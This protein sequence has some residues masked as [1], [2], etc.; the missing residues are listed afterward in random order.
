MHARIYA[1]NTAGAFVGALAAGFWL[2][3]Q[4]GLVAVLAATSV[5]NLVAGALYVGLGR[6]ARGRATSEA[7][8][9]ATPEETPKSVTH[10]APARAGSLAGVALLVGFAMMALQTTLVRLGG[11]ALGPS[12]Y[13]F[14]M[15]V[16]VFVLCIA[17][18]SFAVGALARV[19][20][21]ALPCA[22]WTLAVLLGALYLHADDAPYW[23]HVLRSGFPREPEAF[24]SFQL[25]AFGSL[26]CVSGPP[27]ILSGA[28]LP[29]VFDALKRERVDLGS[30]AG[31]IYA[32]NT[33]GSL[34]GALVGGYTL[35]FWLDLHAVVRVAIA[36]V[37]LAAALATLR[38]RPAWRLASVAATAAVAA[39]GVALP[40]LPPWDPAR[41]SAGLFREPLL[42]PPFDSASDFW[43]RWE[44]WP[45]VF[46]TDDPTASVAVKRSP[47]S[48]ALDGEL[49]LFT[50]GKADGSV[51][52]DYLT[53]AMAGLLPA[54]LA[55]QAERAFVIGYGTGITAGVLA[56]LDSIEQVVVAEISPG[57]IEAAPL[58][59]WANGDASHH[60]KIELER[61]DALR[62][63]ARSPGEF[64][65]VVSEPSNPWMAG[66]ELL[67]SRE[68]LETSR[69]RLRPGGVH[70]QWLPAYDSDSRTLAMVLHTY[71]EVFEHVAVWCAVGSDLL[72]L[73]LRDA[74]SALDVAR[75]EA[76]ARRADFA[77]ALTRAGI[78]S[79]PALLAHELLPLGVANALE[80]PG[81]TH[82]LLHPRLGHLA[83]RAFFAGGVSELPF[84]GTPEAREAG[85][86][87]SL[88]KRYAEMAPAGLS[89]RD[90]A[91]IASET[92]RYRP[93][94]CVAW[95]AS[96]MFSVPESPV[97]DALL[98][99][100]PPAARLELRAAP[101]LALIQGDGDVTVSTPA[102][103]L[104]AAERATRLYATYYHH[105]APPSRE[106]VRTLWELC[107]GTPEI[108]ADCRAGR[109]AAEQ[110]I[111]PLRISPGPH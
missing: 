61:G 93:R 99:S 36:A 103:R 64:D 95:L 51:R 41:L 100:L 97:R 101:L 20:A 89:E 70:L 32:A 45:L 107:E 111:G 50:N 21:A 76:R 78:T 74:D 28:V 43:S 48:A 77:R 16:A 10:A 96:W 94:E 55:P 7:T 91:A 2:V 38:L 44:D 88:L 68:F 24:L 72:V 63:L 40:L 12:E 69:D 3:E 59:D 104:P 42:E 60:P 15:V 79:F 57:V 56:S 29:L 5:V 52:H 73:G 46:Y 34:L 87:S 98:A 109:A 80:L 65:L 47:A 14:S 81:P 90:R 58:F 26:L 23:A 86:R 54:L 11:L 53:Q 67:F 75:L 4:L 13:T 27:V 8:A 18:G 17:L 49:V 83:A 66:V 108:E 19:P 85:Q 1:L 9:A 92:C 37:A 6:L 71:A 110:R 25:A 31:R 82:T 39:V 30:V 35:L 84:T 106:V 33:L 62:A 102:R 22:L 105:A